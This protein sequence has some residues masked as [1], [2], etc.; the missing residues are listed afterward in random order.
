MLGSISKPEQKVDENVK[1]EKPRDDAEKKEENEKIEE[2]KA[3]EEEK[4]QDIVFQVDC[5]CLF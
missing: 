4:E 1:E 2:S 5:F 3:E